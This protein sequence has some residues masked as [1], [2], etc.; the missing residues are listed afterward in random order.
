MTPNDFYA[1]TFPRYQALAENMSEQVANG[2]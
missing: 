1:L 2:D